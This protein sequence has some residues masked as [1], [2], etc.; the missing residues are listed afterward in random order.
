MVLHTALW[1]RLDLPDALVHGTISALE[2]SDEHPHGGFLLDGAG[3][4]SDRYGPWSSRFSVVVDP[5]WRTRA[6]FVEVLTS[7]DGLERVSL[8]VDERGGW[9]IDG[10]EWPELRGCDDVDLSVTP[11]TNTMPVRR[12]G[13]DVGE[14]ATIDVAWLDMPSLAVHRVPQT[15]RRLP[16]DD[17]GRVC[18]TYAD[19]AF[20]PF[21]LSVDSVGVVVDY[22]G[23]FER[24]G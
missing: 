12:L 11:M 16:D 7:H 5:G 15:Y 6:V 14:E 3:V 2:E 23:L 4:V 8:S 9:T 24:V 17:R 21:V 19:P 10:R 22:Q 13:L 18:F 20:G 1:R